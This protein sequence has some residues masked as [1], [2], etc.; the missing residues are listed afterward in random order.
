LNDRIFTEFKEI[1]EKK[2]IIACAREPRRTSTES[3][4]PEGN[5]G[6]FDKGAGVV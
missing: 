6:S 3:L 4:F 1:R 5:L 2:K